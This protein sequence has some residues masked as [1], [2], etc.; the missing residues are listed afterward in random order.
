MIRTKEKYP[1]ESVGNRVIG[2]RILDPGGCV[3]FAIR[4]WSDWT[5]NLPDDGFTRLNRDN[6][7]EGNLMEGTRWNA[8][9]IA[10]PAS[11]SNTIAGNTVKNTFGH[12]G[13]EAD[14]GAIGNTFSDNLVDGIFPGAGGAAYAAYCD[15]GVPAVDGKHPARLA[16]D[17]IWTNNRALNGNQGGTGLAV[18][19]F[20]VNGSKGVTIRGLQ[21]DGFKSNPEAPKNVAGIWVAG[22]FEDAVIDG[23]VAKNMPIGIVLENGHPQDNITISNCELEATHRTLWLAGAEPGLEKGSVTLSGNII[24][25]DPEQRPVCGADQCLQPGG[26][27]PEYHFREEGLSR[28]GIHWSRQD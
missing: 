17:N 1:Q 8:I 3:S 25:C 20:Y 27:V 2:N 14:K 4:I 21:V 18:F 16:R 19:G 23:C 10:G 11:R 6:V 24:H 5:E 15:Q 22:A 7:L 28:N 12:R 26:H 9:E 13:I